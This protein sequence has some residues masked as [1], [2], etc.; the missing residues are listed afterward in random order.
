LASGILS[1]HHVME[2]AIGTDPVRLESRA[3]DRVVIEATP[4]RLA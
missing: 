3:R 1:V 2:D 4:T